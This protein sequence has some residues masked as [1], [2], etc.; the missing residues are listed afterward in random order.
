M[1]E[2]HLLDALFGILHAEQH[3]ENMCL[4]TCEYQ[5]TNHTFCDQCSSNFAHF[6]CPP[7]PLI[8]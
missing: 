8:E 1:S 2:V 5:Y 6:L 7:A 3:L 4:T